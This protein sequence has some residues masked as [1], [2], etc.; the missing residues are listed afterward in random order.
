MIKRNILWILLIF[1]CVSGITQAVEVGPYTV[2]E[3]NDNVYHVEDGN[4]S[5][6]PGVQIGDDGQMVSMNN[7]SDMYLIVGTKK[8]LLIDLSNEVT[9][10]DAA[11]ESLRS[12]VYERVGKRKFVITVTHRHGD[13][14]GMLLAFSDDPKATF[15]LPEKEFRDMDI[16]PAERTVY[17]AE[18]ASIDLGGDY[19][20]R[21]MEVS[22]H[23][24]H[25]TLFFLAGKDLVFTGDAL[26]SGSGVWLF[27]EDSFYTYKDAI[28]KLISY[29]EDPGH[30]INTEKLRIWGGHSWQ[31]KEVG[32]LTA[33]YIYDMHSLIGEMK[34][35]KVEAQDYSTFISFLDANFTYGTATIT[36][37]KE[38]ARRFADAA[39]AE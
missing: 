16:F 26:G 39:D 15:W 30:N 34:E 27:N 14:L 13:H 23:T 12:L 1:L 8:A 11:I 32:E 33:Q 5:N 36:W 38:A 24:P 18:N 29:I 25:S 21:T 28:D 9:W 6:P 10:H 22:G 20:I 7:C 19:V 37:N 31:G 17:F 35:G 2:T 4:K 3:I